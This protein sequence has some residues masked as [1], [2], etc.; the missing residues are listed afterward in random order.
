MPIGIPP[1]VSSPPACSVKSEIPPSEE[2]DSLLIEIDGDIDMTDAHS[3]K[4]REG[5][6]LEEKSAKSTRARSRSR[7]RERKDDD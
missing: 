1:K 6:M 4:K 7:S 3:M 2:N 5:T